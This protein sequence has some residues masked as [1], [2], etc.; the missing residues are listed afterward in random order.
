MRKPSENDEILVREDAGIYTIEHVIPDAEKA[1]L[2]TIGELSID[3]NCI[4]TFCQYFGDR[5][6]ISEFKIL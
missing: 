3:E 4:S 5:K 2:R 6:I 1:T